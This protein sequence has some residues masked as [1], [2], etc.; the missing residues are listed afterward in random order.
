MRS[1]ILAPAFALMIGTAMPAFAA[2]AAPAPATA[3]PAAPAL[4]SMKISNG[5]RKA[6][7]DFQAANAA[8]DPAKIAAATAAAQAAAKTPDD[9]CVF[10]Q[11]ALKA[12]AEN[13]DYVKAGAAVDMMLQS[14]A[15]NPVALGPIAS[16]VGKMRYNAKDYA[17]ASA[18]FD[19]ALR[20]NPND[21]EAYVLSGESKAK[22]NQT[23]AA[24][25]QFSKAFDIR[26]SAGQPIDESWLKRA[27]ALAYDAKSPRTYG[28]SR[29]W[30]SAYPTAKNWRDSLK[31]YQAL[32]GM[33]NSELVDVYRLQRANKALMGE[34]DYAN[35]AS[36]LLQK[37]YPGEAKAMLEE[38][39]AS[40]AVSRSSPSIGPLLAQ[41]TAKAA[42]DRAALAAG[43]AAA[44]AASSGTRAMSIAD[45][46]YGYGEYAK[47]AALYR[48]A[49]AK[50]G[51]DVATANLRLGMSL[52][53]AGDKAGARAALSAVTGP[54]AEIAQYWMTYLALHA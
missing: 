35:Y 42:G 52:A 16:S 30:L 33:P 39:I 24:L 50:S 4:C 20:I 26:K 8:K 48:A 14:G 5:A 15:S 36:A 6:L 3:A 49:L 54:K 46:Y 47:A 9:K 12:A 22:L 23:D 13:N 18:A 43:A 37:G 53:M 40:S 29:Q 11:L 7:V 2:A 31:V 34:A 17:G 32:S 1:T 41:A 44:A 27:V 28:F 19:T 45:A 25:A 10:G 38:G 21:P 51:T